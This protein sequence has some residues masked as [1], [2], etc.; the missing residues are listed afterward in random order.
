M[1]WPGKVPVGRVSDAVFATIDFIPTFASLAG[2]D[3]PDDRRIDGID[4]TELLFGK[5]ETGRDHFYFQAAGVR[6]GKWK[7]L[8]ADAHFYGYAIE[9]D[10]EKAEEL[11]DLEAD[12]GEQ[13]N[14]ATKF[15]ERVAELRA[16]MQSIEGGDKLDPAAN[17]R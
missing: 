2:F 7:Y 8:K 3:V 6:Q 9:N 4:Q 17:K 14:L 1:R 10:R 13:S 5:R 15:P 11:Y 12:L 16:L